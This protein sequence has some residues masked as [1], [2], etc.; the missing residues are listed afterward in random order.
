M[1]A[2]AN[3]E[4]DAYVRVYDGEVAP[5][6]GIFVIERKEL[7]GKTPE[8]VQAHF[9]LTFLPR[10][11]CDANFPLGAK[12]ALGK[13]TNS[14]GKRVSVF[15]AITAL[16]LSAQRPLT[17]ENIAPVPA[18]Q[19][20]I[21]SEPAKAVQTPYPEPLDP[22]DGFNIAN[23]QQY[24]LHYFN[25][26]AEPVLIPN[27]IKRIGPDGFP[28]VAAEFDAPD[29]TRGAPSLKIDDD[30]RN[31]LVQ[32]L[33]KE[34]MGLAVFRHSSTQPMW[35]YTYGDIMCL[36]IFGGLR[37]QGEY[38]PNAYPG[39]IDAV[40]PPGV[41]IRQGRPS[42][43]MLPRYARRVIADRIS[44]AVGQAVRHEFYVFEIPQIDTLRRLKL[45][46]PE[47]STMSTEQRRE[48]SKAVR[49]CL[50]Y[51]LYVTSSP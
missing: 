14:Y 10:M 20:A 18:A 45:V 3:L 32:S 19:S 43:Q 13:L 31:S 24:L 28:Y 38:D 17:P 2:V 42:D 36:N 30:L 46:M 35:A 7:V 1:T 21:S 44:A 23:A 27:S 48:L 33:L 34:G 39:T 6:N 9:S 47:W 37:P 25:K 26:D 50:P 12:F 5:L 8:E 49:W 29:E 15:R 41:S 11:I 4:T 16:N 22:S 51:A 40:L